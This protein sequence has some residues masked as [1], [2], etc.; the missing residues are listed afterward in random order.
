M[1][2]MMYCCQAVCQG[3]ALLQLWYAVSFYA[4]HVM[5]WM[6]KLQYNWLQTW[7]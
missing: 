5:L 6:Q 4:V 3:L 1:A 2:M 7:H